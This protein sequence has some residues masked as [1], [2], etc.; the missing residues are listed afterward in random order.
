M[1]LRV[2]SGGLLFAVGSV[3]ILIYVLARQM[4]G[5]RSMAATAMLLGSSSWGILRWLTGYWL[6]S[7]YALLHNRLLLAYLV[8]MG[9]LGAAVTYMYGGVENTRLNT[10]LRVGLQLFGFLLIYMGTWTCSSLYAAVVAVA[11]LHRCTT[12]IN[13]ALKRRSAQNALNKAQTAS[14]TRAGAEFEEKL[15]MTPTGPSWAQQYAQSPLGD[16]PLADGDVVAR[17]SPLPQTPLSLQF[18]SGSAS[19]MALDQFDDCVP[20]GLI[21]G[22][23]N[24]M[25][26][27]GGEEYEELIQEGRP[28]L[29]IEDQ[30]PKRPVEH[31]LTRELGCSPVTAFQPSTRD[32]ALSHFFTATIMGAQSW[33]ELEALARVHSSSF[34]HVHV[35]ALVCRLPKVVNPVE[36]S[37][38]EK[39]QFSRFLRDVSDLVTIRLS[40][41]DP[42]AIANVLWGVSKLGY[43]PAPPTLNKFLFEAYVRMYDF[44][45]QELANLAWALAT[46]A[47]LGNRPVPMWLR[48]Y[49]LAAVPRVLD[50]KPQELAHMVWALSKLF[51]PATAVSANPPEPS[52]LLPRAARASTG[53][54]TANELQLTTQ[55]ASSSSHVAASHEDV[56]NRS[57]LPASPPSPSSPNG[58]GSSANPRGSASMEPRN[59]ATLSP[60]DLAN[61]WQVLGKCAADSVLGL[62]LR[63][64]ENSGHSSSSGGRRSGSAGRAGVVV[65]AADIA[66]ADI[67]KRTPAAARTAPCTMEPRLGRHQLH[68]LLDVT[69][70]ALHGFTAQGLCLVLWS[71]ARLRLQPS[72]SVTEAVFQRFSRVLPAQSTFQCIAISQWAAAHLGLRPPPP[73]MALFMSC[74]RLQAPAS[75]VSELMALLWALQQMRYRPNKE[76]LNA[77]N[78]RLRDSAD[79]LSAASLQQVFRA[80]AVFGS[81]VPREIRNRALDVLTAVPVD[82]RVANA[83]VPAAD[84]LAPLSTAGLTPSAEAAAA[85]D[86]PEKKSGAPG[87]APTASVPI[88]WLLERPP[89]AA[90][91]YFA[92]LAGLGMGIRPDDARRRRVSEMQVQLLRWRLEA[93]SELR[94]SLRAAMEGAVRGRLHDLDA[95]ALCVLMSTLVRLHVKPG[96]SFLRE[97]YEEV[98]ARVCRG[99]LAHW[100]VGWLLASLGRLHVRPPPELLA[101][102]L[103]ALGPHLA[104]LTDSQLLS[105]VQALA[106]LR[107]RPSVM[108]MRSYFAECMARIDVWPAAGLGVFLRSLGVL[109]LRL[110]TSSCR[111]LQVVV[112]R[113]KGRA[114]G[115][116]RAAATRRAPKK[117]AAA[118]E[119][120]LKSSLC[121]V[122]SELSGCAI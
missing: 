36:L 38:S 2:T 20:T 75:K 62:E 12:A 118:R 60:Q 72:G 105:V 97:Y 73:T 89:C 23:G 50:L 47:S 67:G 121:A 99:G 63:L 106:R 10:V 107:F 86:A 22:P 18:M 13:T 93:S 34:N 80:Y 66:A 48:K 52:A 104:G 85:A 7:G 44:N 29:T 113:R 41:F 96:A 109:G 92:T 103:A 35:S 100:H 17:V 21:R 68:A 43:S 51:P 15:P 95:D 64:P 30:A 56:S 122:C 45:A 57:H 19:V 81:P 111:Q 119:E 49:T 90:V 59:T 28:W 120:D 65:P 76:L 82:A 98:A 88:P 54:S 102:L 79:K 16:V 1:A 116:E 3:L 4:P 26:V 108:W 87:E 40:A 83:T 61:L 74:A 53:G 42:R 112:Y 117:G 94:R 71:W 33:Q 11:L 46:L 78:A 115:S 39:T 37:K 32:R 27:I 101:R 84:G 77:F 24:K 14:Q 70:R 31:T 25:I 55:T 69:V 58:P 5:R 6:P 110:G 9:L 8:V 114:A 91:R